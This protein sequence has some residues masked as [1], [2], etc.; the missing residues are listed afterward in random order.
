MQL[1]KTEA[2][3]SASF[4]PN[5]FPAL[6]AGEWGEDEFGLWMVLTFQGVRQV[7][8]WI[9]PGTFLMGSPK[10]E[11]ERYDDETQHP[12]TLTQGYWLADTACTQALWEAVMGE[13]PAYF[14]DDANN[15]V[16]RVSWDDVQQFIDK[17]NGLIPTLNARLPTEAQWEYA[18]RAGT[19]TPFSFGKNITP[20]QVNYNG[21]YPYA[22]GKE[23]LYRKKT[24]P[25]KSLPLNPWGLFEMH[26]NV[27]EWCS[28]WFVS[29]YPT[30]SVVDPEGPPSGAS[31]VLRGGSWDDFGRY[32]R[33]AHR[34]R[35][36][37]GYRSAVGFRLSLGQV[38]STWQVTSRQEGA[39]EAGADK[40]ITHATR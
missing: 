6:W 14:K 13:N 35:H 16:E 21:N 10:S 20:E 18:C 26:G 29:D 30:E 9:L 3:T 4:F 23:G 11:P 12:V 15:P 17:L 1:A 2:Q 40:E 5:P 31:R 24:V 8:R 34:I 19:T 33:S 38:A 7:F 39:S 28:D 36:Q 32:V 25:V 27:W 37:P 22:G